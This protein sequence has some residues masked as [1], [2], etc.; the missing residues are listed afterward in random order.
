MILLIAETKYF[1]GKY[2][3][4]IFHF[5]GHKLCLSALYYCGEQ[6]NFDSSAGL[7]S[8]LK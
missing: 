8:F 5:R 3:N 7:M 1:F 4:V 6:S 2:L